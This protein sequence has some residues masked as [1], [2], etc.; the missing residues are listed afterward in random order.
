MADRQRDELLTIIEKQR[1][2]A[3]EQCA[4]ARFHDRRKGRMEFAFTCRFDNQDLTTDDATCRL[5]LS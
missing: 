5:C 1:T 2:A 4:G 3:D